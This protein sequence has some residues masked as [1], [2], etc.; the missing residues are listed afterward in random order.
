MHL[1]NESSM[2][3]ALFEDFE[4]DY[5]QTNGFYG[6]PAFME[7][8]RRFDLPEQRSAMILDTFTARKDAISH[9]ID[10]S[11]LSPAAK[12]NYQKRFTNRLYAIRPN[13]K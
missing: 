7:L 13:T 10:Q 4:S 6:R 5:F 9:L 12:Q 3:L 1:P 2:A 11:F 8:A